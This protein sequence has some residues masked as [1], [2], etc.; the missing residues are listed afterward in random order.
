MNTTEGYYIE[1]D[2]EKYR[3]VFPS[4]ESEY[5]ES[6]LTLDDA[7]D[8]MVNHCGVSSQN[9]TVMQVPLLFVG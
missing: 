4:V 1:H 6:H 8:W 9:I 3:S 7:F 5:T 2:G